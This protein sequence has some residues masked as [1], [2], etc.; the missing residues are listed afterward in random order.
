MLGKLPKPV[1]PFDGLIRFMWVARV[2]RTV[3][4]PQVTVRSVP[5]VT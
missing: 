3:V 2:G 4:N 1:D 5:T